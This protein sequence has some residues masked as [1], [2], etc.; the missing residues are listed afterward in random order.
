MTMA[1]TSKASAED[2]GESCSSV[3]SDIQLTAKIFEVTC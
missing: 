1:S 3:I 2:S